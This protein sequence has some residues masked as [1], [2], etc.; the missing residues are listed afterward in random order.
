MRSNF[1]SERKMKRNNL[2]R[3]ILRNERSAEGMLS[4]PSRSNSDTLGMINPRWNKSMLNKN[5]VKRRLFHDNNHPA[6]YSISVPKEAEKE[7]IKK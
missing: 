3:A 4:N 7:F 1:E 5:E 6:A 2:Y